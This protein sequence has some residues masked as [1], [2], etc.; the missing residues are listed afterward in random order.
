MNKISLFLMHLRLHGRTR[1]TH[2]QKLGVFEQ[3]CES[4]NS[5][6][7]A[8]LRWYVIIILTFKDKARQHFQRIC[9][10]ERVGKKSHGSKVSSCPHLPVNLLEASHAER[11]IMRGSK[12]SQKRRNGCVCFF[13]ERRRTFGLTAEHEEPL[14]KRFLKS[15]PDWILNSSR[16]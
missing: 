4:E 13:K 1:N 8:H 10:G 6:T 2:V 7:D 12:T 15:L 16:T 3:K 5:P 14:G 9:P 11:T